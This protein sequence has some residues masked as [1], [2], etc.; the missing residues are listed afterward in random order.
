MSR[1]IT[2]LF[3]DRDDAMAGRQRL[4]D[5]RID[6]DNIRV[7]DKTELTDTGYTDDSSHGF[8][9]SIKNAFLPDEDRHAYE[10]GMRRGGYLLTADVDNDDIDD[11]I[12]ALEDARGVDIDER[13]TGWRKEG[14]SAP[15]AAATSDTDQ[16]LK[17]VEEQLVVGKHEVERG[18]VRVRSY[19]TE[20]PVHEQ[21]A[22]RQERVNVERR[23][24]D[25]DAGM[26]GDTAFQDRTIEVTAT[27]EEAVVGKTARVVE[28]V[29]ISKDVE[30][31]NKDVEGTVRRHDVEVEQI[32]RT[33]NDRAD[34]DR[35]ITDRLDGNPRT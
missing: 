2:A 10:E 25:R 31:V 3:D 4:I 22:L 11:A 7:H 16:T 19:V 23:P 18:G 14:W 35:S 15:A 24:V 30:V 32:G 20:T 9:G 26:V 12:R 6:A 21:I 34:G 13:S 17:V 8:W 29:V 33:A 28:E 5:A 27:S 1:T